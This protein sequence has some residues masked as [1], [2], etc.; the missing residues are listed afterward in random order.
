MTLGGEESQERANILGP[1]T[2]IKGKSFFLFIDDY[3]D[4]LW[5]NDYNWNK[6]W[7]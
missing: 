2:Y 5:Q 6:V 3:I 7:L 1:K 4:V